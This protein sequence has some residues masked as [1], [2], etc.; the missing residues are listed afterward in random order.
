MYRDGARTSN[1]DKSVLTDLYKSSRWKR[2]VAISV[3]EERKTTTLV[4]KA[5]ASWAFAEWLNSD[6]FDADFNMEI[7]TK[8]HPLNVE[9]SGI[10]YVDPREKNYER[11]C[12]KAVATS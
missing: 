6:L 11:G 1:L 7:I 8:K 5:V 4:M 3:N 12:D 10:Q 9:L 2:F